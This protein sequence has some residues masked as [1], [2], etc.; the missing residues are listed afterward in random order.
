MLCAGA[1]FL[2]AAALLHKNEKGQ[3]AREGCREAVGFS[4]RQM[5]TRASSVS[6]GVQ[7]CIGQ[8]LAAEDGSPQL[9]QGTQHSVLLVE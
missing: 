5:S 2:W 4:L 7:G 1:L 8:G 3:L 9:D 6:Q